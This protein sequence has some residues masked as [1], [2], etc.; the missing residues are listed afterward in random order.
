MTFILFLEAYQDFNTSVLKTDQI[1][2]DFV[3]K[4][5]GVRPLSGETVQAGSVNTP[6]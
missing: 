2:R 5:H 4:L 3:Q 6:S 1:L